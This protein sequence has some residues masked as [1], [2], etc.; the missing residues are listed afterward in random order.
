M[1]NVNYK[2]I[3]AMKKENEKRILKVCDV[4]NQSGIYCFYRVNEQGF[5]F[6]YVGQATK[7]VLS[8]LADHLNGYKQHI[9]LSLRKHG[10]YDEKKNPYGYK[11]KVLCYCMDTE[12]DEKEQNY[13]KKFADEGWQLKN[14]TGGSQGK[15]KF[16][17]NENKS[18][19]GYYEGFDNGY[20]KAQK[21]VAHLFKLHLDVKTKKDVPT[22]LQAK[23]LDKFNYFIDIE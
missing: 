19:R 4:D 16:A 13:I 8:R 18:S 5:K 6:A 2:K 9:D 12:C 21:E 3:Y 11:A 7:S 1:P 15:G 17:I 10:L 23:A 20:K 14:T 22:K